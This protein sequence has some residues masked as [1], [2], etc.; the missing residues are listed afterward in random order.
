MDETADK[1]K[2]FSEKLSGACAEAQPNTTTGASGLYFLTLET[3]CRDFFSASFV[4]A[5]VLSR[6]KSAAHSS[7]VTA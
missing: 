6:Y 4:T 5:Q 7:S 3:A 1:A 2:S